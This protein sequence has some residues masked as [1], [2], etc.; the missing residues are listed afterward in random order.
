MLSFTDQ[1]YEQRFVRY[2]H[3]FYYRYAQIS[4]ALGLVLVFGDFLVDL[5]AFPDD[6]ANILRVQLCIPIL[7]AGIVCSFTGFA[8]RHWQSVMAGFI[9]VVAGSLFWVLIVI[10]TTGGMG[11]RSWVGILN[12]I[13]LEFYCF[14]IL[15][16]QFRYAI[17]A[18][19][20][21]LLA[22][23]AAM[24]LTFGMDRRTFAYWSYHVVT[25]FL[26]A[27][28]IGWWREFVLRK[29]FSAKTA[30]KAARLTAEHLT[31]VKSDFL[32]TMSHEIRTPMNAIIGMSRLALQTDLMP[33]QRDYIEKV[34][35]SGQHLLGLINE[36]LDFSKVEAGKLVMEEAAFRLEDVMDNV[37]NLLAIKAEEKRLDFLFDLAPDVPAALVGDA[38]RLGQVLVNLGNN[39]VKFTDQGEVIIGAAPVSQTERDVELHFWVKDSGI[40]MTPEQQSKL[41]QSFSQADAST[42]RKYGGTGLGLAISKKLVELMGGRIWIESQPGTGSIFHFHARFGRP[43]EAT[44]RHTIHA[45]SLAGKRVLV[46]DDNASAREI[47]VTMA[48][49]LG[50]GRGQRSGWPPGVWPRSK[51]TTNRA[52]RT[53]WLSWTGECRAWMAWNAF[54]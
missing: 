17:V 33:K 24:S 27:V 11:L 9:V 6:H 20:L 43:A 16:V 8:K 35:R 34:S 47:L 32:A 49:N 23:E 22:F 18:G 4:L 48:R 25:L 41:F 45:G 29:D 21:I 7:A 26:L 50:P 13:F 1:A 12:F 38:L 37:A 10:D 40:G 19:L 30:L 42:T 46:V 44:P 28:V 52:G 36:V 3:D 5:L 15:G 2:Y 53:I 31:R 14:V 39:A 51:P 54:A